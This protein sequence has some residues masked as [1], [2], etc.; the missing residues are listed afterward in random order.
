MELSKNIKQARQNTGLTQE[1][2]AKKIGI[3]LTLMKQIEG[4]HETFSVNVLTRIVEE[5]GVEPNF[6]FGFTQAQTNEKFYLQL[7][8]LQTDIK[9]M[10]ATLETMQS[11]INELAH[12][13][14]DSLSI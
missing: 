4:G 3:S 6:L 8:T 9:T 10:S 11:K 5:F 12:K 1:E 14:S 7:Q 2:F 13:I